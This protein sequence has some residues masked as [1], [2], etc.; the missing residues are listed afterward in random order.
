MKTKKESKIN[1]SFKGIAM[2]E[3]LNRL[4]IHEKK[5]L[6][7]WYGDAKR[8]EIISMTEKEI[9]PKKL[10]EW[11]LDACSLI[12][13]KTYNQKAQKPYSELT[14]EQQFIDHFICQQIIAKIKEM[15]K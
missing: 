9:T 15:K 6:E 3:L 11:Y 1:I 8:D 7:F 13:A 2:T 12:R 5:L 10:H 4:T 14:K